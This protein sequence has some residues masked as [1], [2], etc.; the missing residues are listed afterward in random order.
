MSRED[1]KQI[2]RSVYAARVA[3]DIAGVADHLCDDVAFEIH[4]AG[5]GLPGMSGPVSGKAA[6][7][8]LIAELIRGFHFS[9]WQ[10]ISLIAEGDHAALHWRAKVTCST[11]GKSNTFDV[12]DF[13][14]FRDNKIR[15][16][17]QFTDTAK[18]MQMVSAT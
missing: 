17:R 2:I 11:N 4:G 10:E 14:S 9:D 18:L 5:T 3:D 13:F 8:P 12:F 16:L 1:H 6:V 15:E 7:E